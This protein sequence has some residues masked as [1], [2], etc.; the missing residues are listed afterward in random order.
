MLA[1]PAPSQLLFLESPADETQPMRPAIPPFA[2]VPGGG[3]GGISLSIAEKPVSGV[4]TTLSP[5]SVPDLCV[6]L[7]GEAAGERSSFCAQTSAR[8]AIHLWTDECAGRGS[9]LRGCVYILCVIFVS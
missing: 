3:A 2:T 9:C 7:D 4:A 6:V 8:A 1:P 5:S